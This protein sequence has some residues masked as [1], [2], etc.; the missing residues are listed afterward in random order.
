M[1]QWLR[2]GTSTA[3]AVGLM[4]DWGNKIPHATWPKKKKER[5][6]KIDERG[7]KRREVIS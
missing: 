3:G 2:L 6:K 1:V 4:P 7:G 5:E